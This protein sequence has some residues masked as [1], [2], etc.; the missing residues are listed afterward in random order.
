MMVATF[1]ML[2]FDEV[3]KIMCVNCLASIT[4]PFLE[5]FGRDG[6]MAGVVGDVRG[7]HSEPH[8]DSCD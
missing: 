5:S 3:T 2:R 1:N 8:R 6:V 7:I 4:L